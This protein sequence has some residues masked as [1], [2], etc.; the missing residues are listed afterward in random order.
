MCI[1][2]TSDVQVTEKDLIVFKLVQKDTSKKDRFF[3]RYPP[4][5]RITQSGYERKGYGRSLSYKIGKITTSTMSKTPGL[6]TYKRYRQLRLRYIE[7][8][9]ILRIKIPAGTKVRFGVDGQRYHCIC[10]ESIL[11][12]RVVKTRR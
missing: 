2:Y 9:C 3:S 4:S 5:H 10:T 11:P 7:S 6:Y 12:L 8:S 1:R